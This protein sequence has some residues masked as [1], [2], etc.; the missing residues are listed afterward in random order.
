MVVSKALAKLPSKPHALYRFFDRTDALLYVGITM[1]LAGRMS[2]HRKD[3]P[4]WVDVHHIS[5]EH[6]DNR[7]SVLA[8][9][10]AAIAS[11]KPLY[12]AAH[13]EMAQSADTGPLV[14]SWTQH[15]IKVGPVTRHWILENWPKIDRITR[16]HVEVPAYRAGR[17]ELAQGII[18]DF[19]SPERNLFME[20]GRLD[21][22]AGGEG[23]LDGPEAYA[24]GL[25]AAVR[26]M[27]MSIAVLDGALRQLMD[28]LPPALVELAQDRHGAEEFDRFTTDDRILADEARALSLLLAERFLAAASEEVRSHLMDGVRD[29]W[30]NADDEYVVREAARRGRA[31]PD[32]REDQEGAQA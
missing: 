13:N 10:R 1:D 19:T 25:Q 3:K 28:Q 17:T 16:D 6:F 7:A 12:N 24:R 21:G 5:I 9:E 2:Q 32:A 4:W 29:D 27:Q 14:V 15:G 18:E 23:E 22:E 11:E 8:A 26:H 30:A 31:T 20:L